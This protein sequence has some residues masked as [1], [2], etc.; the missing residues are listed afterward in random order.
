MKYFKLRHRFTFIFL[1]V[2]CG[3]FLFSCNEGANYIAVINGKKVPAE[4]YLWTQ[5]GT[6]FANKSRQTQKE[7]LEK[8]Y[9][10]ILR[11]YDAQNIDFPGKQ[12]AKWDTYFNQRKA[13]LESLY[14]MVVI[15]QVVQQQDVRKYY[16]RLQEKREV[17]H[18]LISYKD[19]INSKSQRTQKEALRRAR[20]IRKKILSGSL[21]FER[22]A[23][24]YSEDPG[25]KD[26]GLL[27][28][29]S[30]GQMDPEFQ[31]AAWELQ[32][33][34]LSNPV[35]TR[36][37]YH[38][39]EVTNI[40]PVKNLKSFS[41]LYNDIR[42]RIASQ[43]QSEI[44]RLM[45]ETTNEIYNSTNFELDDSLLKN[46]SEELYSLYQKKSEQTNTRDLLDL[47]GEINYT[48]IGNI[49]GQEISR[50]DFRTF[51]NI[52]Q[53]LDTFRMSDETSIARIAK[54]YF[55]Q[56]AFLA[57]GE[58]KNVRKYRFTPYKLRSIQ[59]RAYSN[60]YI[61]NV[62]L[63]DFSSPYDSLLAFYKRRKIKD[64]LDVKEVQVREIYVNYVSTAN[65]LLDSLERGADFAK[66]ASLY[67]QRQSTKDSGG[68]LGW[69]PPDRYGPIGEIAATMELGE[70]RGPIQIG[71]GWSLIKLLGRDP[72]EPVP[73]DSIKQTVKKDYQ[74]LNIN[75]LLQENIEKLEKKYHSRL[76][77]E[78][79]ESFHN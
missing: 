53:H 1:M 74:H 43:H 52:I 15:D 22:A 71:T 76:N 10:I 66:L 29:I 5:I 65:D 32:T 55:Q 78:F 77:Y 60:A 51:L 25:G 45:K 17:R 21:T 33:H 41:A 31:E 7:N 62:I 37:G 69:F 58:R 16:S 35:K 2:L 75:R 79:L 13:L 34:K 6:D 40:D 68:D 73:F 39:I 48:S 26:G 18:I 67:T 38:L 59:D 12:H 24:E 4:Y 27:G 14:D 28:L 61:T 72:N 54:L 50:E 11:S 56:E 30:W 36:Y 49:A 19:A 23:Q 47:F 46:I 42:G 3:L 63:K 8:F 9:H 64:Y 57:Y 70:V 20:Q 44:D